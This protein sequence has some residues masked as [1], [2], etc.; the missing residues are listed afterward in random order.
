[1]KKRL[2]PIPLILLIPIVLLIIV[3]VAGI[4]RFSLSDEEILAKF[5]SQISNQDAI[6][7]S[8]FGIRTLN[9][10]TVKIPESSAF[11]FIDDVVEGDLLKGSYEEGAER[12]VVTIESEKIVSFDGN[13]Y[14]SI[15]ALSNQGS[16]LFYYLM[17]SQYDEFRQRLISK[18]SVLLGDRIDVQSLE[19][20]DKQ[21]VVVTFLEHDKNQAM[22]EPP[23]KQVKRIFVVTNEGQL[24]NQ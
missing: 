24:L 13:T 7:Q 18:D 19:E 21:S 11:T 16:G 20:G 14:V 2:L 5:P 4:Y 9:P 12:G 23:S 8:V 3:A 10:W 15:L 22:A 6:M 1:M 17:L